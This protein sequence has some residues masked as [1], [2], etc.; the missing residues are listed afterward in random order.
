MKKII[1]IGAGLGGLVAGNLLARKG[2]QVTLFESHSSPGG[3]TAGFWRKGFYFESGTLSFESSS[4]IFNAMTDLG[5]FD[6]I[7]FVKQISR[8]I[9]ADFDGITE[10]YGDFKHLFFTA[11]PA[12]Q[13]RLEKY[14]AE[15][16]K[17]YNTMKY[18]GGN[19]K[20]LIQSL[21]NYTIGGIKA[22]RIYQKYSNLT[23]SEFTERFFE[24]DS[25]LYRI[26]KNIGYPDMSAWILGGAVATIFDDYWTVKDGMQSWADML[27]ENFKSLGGELKLNSH[28]DSIM[29]KKGAAVGVTCDDQKYEVDYVIS[30]SDYK[31]TFLK[32][33]DDPSLV[34]QELLEQ[35]KNNAVSEGFFTVYL[36]LDISHERM[37]DFMKIPHVIYIDEQPGADV[38]DPNDESF[39][40]KTSIT[41]YSPSVMNPKLAPEGK[42]SL[43][44]QAVCPTNWME[45][46]GAGN[47]ERYQQLKEKVKNTL[48]KKASS[49][50]PDLQNAIEFQDA[51]T[52]L[53]YERYTQNTGGATSAWSWN[54]NNKFYKSL[55]KVNI[56]TPVKNL[57]IGSCWATQIG[58]VPSAVGAAYRCAKKIG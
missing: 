44:L 28:V 48:I 2:H 12:E 58:G 23:V 53:T 24:K 39:F 1:I 14:F 47:R 9:S 22:L 19:K 30:A 18:F 42:S 51:A 54:P 20:S 33:L 40:E 15:L 21:M 4:M 45:S 50:I 16:D 13:E 25:I 55:V 7:N 31:K 26:F 10:S 32:L 34:P 49:V 5:L 46:W 57:Y 29:T 38:H 36:G 43:M 37:L 56:N 52:P 3:Y 8:W 27:A 35:I 11:Y 6:R 17:M 41:L